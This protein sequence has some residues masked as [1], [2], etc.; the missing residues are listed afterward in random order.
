MRAGHHVD[1]VVA[2][3]LIT[4]VVL[5][6]VAGVKVHGAKAFKGSVLKQKMSIYIVQLSNEAKITFDSTG[7]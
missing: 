2:A 7:L 3:G 4:S 6:V 5:V 1:H